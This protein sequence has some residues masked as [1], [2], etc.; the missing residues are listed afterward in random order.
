M[1]EALLPFCLRAHLG[2][3]LPLSFAFGVMTLLV[4]RQP[5]LTDECT[6]FVGWF[7]FEQIKL[8]EIVWVGKGHLAMKLMLLGAR[9][10][11]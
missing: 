7:A 10:G 8:W 3:S 9:E 4:C 11:V 6:L 2:P 5:K 1:W